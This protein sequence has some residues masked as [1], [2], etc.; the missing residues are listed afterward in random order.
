MPVAPVVDVGY[1]ERGREARL[2]E[3]IQL[4][5]PDG[6][7]V[8]QDVAAAFTGVLGLCGFKGIQR[9]VHSP[10][11][12]CV[13]EELPVPVRLLDDG[14]QLLTRIG[15]VALVIGIALERGM[16]GL[17]QEGG[18]ALQRAVAHDFHAAGGYLAL[19]VQARIV[20][21]QIV[22]GVDVRADGEQPPLAG[23][24]Q[25]LGAVVVEHARVQRGGD[26][27]RRV[28]LPRCPGDV[29]HLM[30]AGKHGQARRNQIEQGAFLDHAV[31][32]AVGLAADDPALWIR[33]VAV[34]AQRGEPGAVQRPR[35][36]WKCAARGWGVRC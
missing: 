27:A 1:E 12:V 17:G 30:F 29:L 7:G 36:G 31:Q 25:G 34:D 2:A 8:D 16:V 32:R 20:P 24:T 35:S 10:V 19:K 9:V 18:E 23:F 3:P 15:G 33:R 22:V 13:D 5:V 4:I 6:L 28:D 14:E 11:A 21:V 26:A